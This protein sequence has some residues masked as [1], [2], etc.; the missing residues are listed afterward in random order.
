[1]KAET[2]EAYTR[3][4]STFVTAIEATGAE[5]P[6]DLGQRLD[7]NPLKACELLNELALSC[8]AVNEQLDATLAAIYESMDANDARAE[9]DDETRARIARA[10]EGARRTPNASAGAPEPCD[11]PANASQPAPDS[12][13]ASARH[14]A[15]IPEGER[16]QKEVKAAETANEDVVTVD[17]AIAIL[18]LSRPTVY[19]FIENGKLPA[20]KRGRSWQI[21]ASAVAELAAT[22]K[23]RKPRSPRSSSGDAIRLG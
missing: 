20:Y 15:L 8:G 16:E 6:Y 13:E 21:S 5:L 18:G 10:L 1:M 14:T 19:K 4:V 23:P 7:A 17:Q 22:K 2:S 12:P 11:A 9:A 3:L